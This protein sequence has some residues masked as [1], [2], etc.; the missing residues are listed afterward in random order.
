MNYSYL[1]RAPLVHLLQAEADEMESPQSRLACREALSARVGELNG[2]GWENLGTI[3][4]VA[5]VRFFNREAGD[6]ARADA[7]IEKAKKFDRRIAQT[8]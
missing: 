5:M 7:A 2:G 6:E 4:R 1:M 8:S 3:G